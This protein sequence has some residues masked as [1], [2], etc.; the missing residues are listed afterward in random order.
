[1]AAAD[2]PHDRI[3]AQTVGVV[4]VIIPAK[5]AKNG[6][7]KLPDHVIPPVLAGTAVFEKALANPGQAKGIV[8]FPIGEQSGV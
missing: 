2:P 1:L 8:K 7:A 5:T 6:L 3:T 4:H